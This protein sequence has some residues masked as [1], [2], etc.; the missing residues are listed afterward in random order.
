MSHLK[1]PELRN[2]IFPFLDFSFSESI[3]APFL[4]AF[5]TFTFFTF[6]FSA[7]EVLDG[8]LLALEVLVFPPVSFG[9][10]SSFVSVST[11]VPKCYIEQ[12][13]TESFIRQRPLHQTHLQS[14]WT[15]IVCL[16]Q[17]YGR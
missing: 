13:S 2:K 10:V 9:S 17:S 7:F 14:D 8:T 15:L 5:S 4:L 11:Q 6:F 12:L 16:I 1:F 3:L